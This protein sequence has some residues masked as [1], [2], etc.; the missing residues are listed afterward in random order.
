MKVI[1]TAFQGKL[2]SEVMDWPEGSNPRIH[3]RMDMD[4]YHRFGYTG[5]VEVANEP[6]LK[7]GTF[8]W[9]GKYT[10]ETYGVSKESARVYVLTEVR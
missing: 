7:M 9:N 10:L 8:E 4:S 1:L 6:K 3:L 2:V 5:E